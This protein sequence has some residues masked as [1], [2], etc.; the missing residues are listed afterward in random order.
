MNREILVLGFIRILFIVFG[1]W[2]IWNSI[3]FPI[4]RIIGPLL[5]AFLIFVAIIIKSTDLWGEDDKK[6]N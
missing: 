2:I 1:I 5:G 4:I 3:K 6:S